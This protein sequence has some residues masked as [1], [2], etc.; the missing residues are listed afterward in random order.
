MDV[1]TLAVGAEDKELIERRCKEV[2]VEKGAQGRGGKE[3]CCCVHG[4]EGE[5]A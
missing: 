3:A 1:E 4:G 5:E 2:A